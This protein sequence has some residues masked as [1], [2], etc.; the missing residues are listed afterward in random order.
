MKVGN[1]MKP[2][3]KRIKKKEK[4]QARARAQAKQTVVQP[5]SMPQEDMFCGALT[6]TCPL[7]GIGVKPQN[8]NFKEVTK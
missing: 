5:I 3:L 4:Q 2:V 7:T 6:F 1:D 8:I